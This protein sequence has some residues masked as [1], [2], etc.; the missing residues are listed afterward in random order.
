MERR[1]ARS[2]PRPT[3]ALEAGRRG[4][5]CD[6]RAPAGEQ[7]RELA[8]LGLLELGGAGLEVGGELAHLGGRRGNLDARAEL[9]E[10][11]L[12]FAPDLLQDR[13]ALAVDGACA[14]AADGV[15]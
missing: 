5:D 13:E 6:A 2:A 4:R 15:A 9:V 7:R 14:Q 10:E 12:G 11:R 3:T 1:G 8:H